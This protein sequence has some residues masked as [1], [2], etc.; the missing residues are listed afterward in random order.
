[1]QQNHSGGLDQESLAMPDS[2]KAQ[3]VESINEIVSSIKQDI[4]N[5]KEQFA[6]LPPAPNSKY[7][8]KTNLNVFF[9]NSDE[10]PP[11]PLARFH[12]NVMKIERNLD[13]NVG[14]NNK[15]VW[16]KADGKRSMGMQMYP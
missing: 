12:N 16:P 10:K 4:K 14:L 1:M 13:E 5:I 15:R 8:N 6:A 11:S 2:Q 9:A 7:P 3:N